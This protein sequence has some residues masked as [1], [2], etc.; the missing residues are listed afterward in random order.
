MAFQVWTGNEN[1]AFG[2]KGKL[3][4]GRA[5]G[6]LTGTHQ[7]VELQTDDDLLVRRMYAPDQLD[8]QGKVRRATAAELSELKGPDRSLPG[9][10]ADIYDIKDGKVVQVR[11]L[12]KKDDSKSSGKAE[13]EADS[14]PTGSSTNWRTIKPG[15]TAAGALTGTVV[16]Y[17]SSDKKLTLRV[18]SASLAGRNHQTNKKTKKVQLDDVETDM[19]MI[20]TKDNPKAADQPDPKKK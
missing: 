1:T 12:K 20:V 15:W 17:K 13:A 14:K 16:S 4:G 8:E 9:Y 3:P 7:D 11:L 10:K 6:H 19:V 2:Q 18:D 5:Q